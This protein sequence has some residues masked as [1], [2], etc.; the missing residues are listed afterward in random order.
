MTWTGSHEECRK[1]DLNSGLNSRTTHGHSTALYSPGQDD[2]HL[3]SSSGTH[4]EAFL[5]SPLGI[6]FGFKSQDSGEAL[7]HI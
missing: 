4:R 3:L 1:Q 6:S 2:S 7:S 5:N